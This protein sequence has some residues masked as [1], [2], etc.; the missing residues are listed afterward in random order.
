MTDAGELWGT[1]GT[2]AGTELLATGLV[3]ERLGV[4]LM[5]P[6][7][8]PAFAVL[9]NGRRIWRSD[10]S[11]SGTVEFTALPTGQTM[12]APQF[13]RSGGRVAFY[14]KIDGEIEEGNAELW[15]TDGTSAGTEVI[16]DRS[17]DPEIPGN[18]EVRYLT[19]VDGGWIYRDRSVAGGSELWFTDGVGEPVEFDLWPGTDSSAPYI[20]GSALGDGYLVA[21]TPDRGEELWRWDA[22]QSLVVPLPE[23]WPG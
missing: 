22:S 23:L 11:T 5:E 16:T 17:G 19:A 13:S 1:D 3:D 6:S 10:A 7:P 15:W 8:G 4:A 2:T 12:D 21:T 18:A 9:G 20:F 14:A